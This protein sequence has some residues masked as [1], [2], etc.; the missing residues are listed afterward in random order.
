MIA[1]TIRSIGTLEPPERVT[2]RSAGRSR[3]WWIGLMVLLW[4]SA[5]R[6]GLATAASQDIPELEAAIPAWLE[7]RSWLDRGE[8]PSVDDA[9]SRLPIPGLSASGVLLRLDGRVVGRGFDPE[10]DDRSV[11]RA[12]GRALAQATGD[13]VIRD[14][15]EPWRS[16]PGSRLTLE[17]ELAGPRTPLVGGTLAA[18]AQRLEP[19]IDGIAVVRGDRTALSLP[20]RTLATGTGAATA[21]TLIRLID[22]LGLPPR[23]LPELRRLD[24]VR[25]ER[26][27]TLRLGQPDPD[28]MP[29]TR[30][31][32]GPSV[33]R[34]PLAEFEIPEMAATLAKRLE[35]WRAPTPEGI[36]PSTANWLG[37]FDPIANEHRPMVASPADAML[38]AWASATMRGEP[39]P[40]PPSGDD[41]PSPEAMVVDLGLLAA[42]AADDREAAETWLEILERTPNERDSPSALARSAAAL[43]MQSPGIVDDRRFVEAYEAAWAAVQGLPDGIAGF[44]WL[45]LAERAWWQRHGACGP[46]VESVRAIRDALLVRQL[47]APDRD[48]DGSIPLRQGLREVSDARSIRMLV[49][50]AALYGLPDESEDRTRRAVRGLEGLL[51]FTRQLMVSSEEA[52]DL[53]GGRLALGGI[54]AGPATPD[55]PLAATASALIAIDLLVSGAQVGRSLPE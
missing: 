41:T 30:S 8:T 48:I 37:D 27:R 34:V 17:L 16:A 44:D 18:A 4:A 5:T 46:R 29:G 35:A 50:L 36:E 22:E 7:L 19:G 21:S 42:A 38:A 39:P 25:L 43:G 14:L 20:G 12:F 6:P 55:Q 31:R 13:R 53:P 33:R 23:D 40:R 45:A 54:Q 2:P 15:P 28:A 10:G 26:F 11:R 32:L 9:E 51:R 1:R 24:S 47:D 52:R 3:T 49:G